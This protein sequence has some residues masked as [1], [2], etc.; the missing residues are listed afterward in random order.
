MHSNMWPIAT[1]V[2]YGGLRVWGTPVSSAQ[3][4]KPIEVPYGDRE[5]F[6]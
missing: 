6:I 4:D 5:T 2:A 3:T 1:G